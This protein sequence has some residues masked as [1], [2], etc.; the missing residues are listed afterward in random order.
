MHVDSLTATLLNINGKTKDGLNAHL[1]LIEMNMRGKLAPIDM[2]KSTY[3]PPDCY[4]TSKDEKLSFYKCLKDVKVPQGHSSNVKSLMSMQDLKLIGLN[5]HDWHILMQQ[6]L[7]VAIR[8]IL[9]KNVRHTITRLCSFFSSICCK[10]IDPSKID[11]LQNEIVVNLCE[12]E[13]FFL[14]LF[15]TSCDVS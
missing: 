8:V 6:L 14:H 9:L 4:T 15:L 10:V 12:L 2:G 3:L 5:S 7:P 13:M 11:E 1:D